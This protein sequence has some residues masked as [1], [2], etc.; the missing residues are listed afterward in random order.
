MRTA[1]RMLRIETHGDSRFIDLT[2]RVQEVVEQSGIETGI[3]NVQTQHTTA[4][5]AINEDEPLLL[6]DL[7]STL[8]GLAPGTRAY[9]HDDFAVRTVNM[10]PG[11]RPNGHA[12]CQALMLRTSE[13]LNIVAGRIQLG[14]WQRIFLV[15]LDPGR[16]RSVSVLVMGAAPVVTPMTE[17]WIPVAE[18]H[19]EAFD[20]MD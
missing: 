15:E 1:N 6:E 4:A 18:R 8:V 12:H 9:R 16:Q 3:V 17:R 14:R 7:V 13:T 20:W 11:E 2:R 10:T 5:I 19:Q